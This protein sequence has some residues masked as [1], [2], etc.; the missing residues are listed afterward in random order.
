[1]SFFKLD[2]LFVS[3][4]AIDMVVAC[5]NTPLTLAGSVPNLQNLD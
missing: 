2:S 5:I 3:I 1:V 4:R